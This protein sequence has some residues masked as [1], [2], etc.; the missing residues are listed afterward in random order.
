MTLLG[1]LP[2]K[3]EFGVCCSWPSNNKNGLFLSSPWPM[4]GIMEVLIWLVLLL[5]LQSS[6]L[7]VAEDDDDFSSQ[8]GVL[9]GY[10][11]YS[12]SSNCFAEPIGMGECGLDSNAT[13]EPTNATYFTARFGIP[14]NNKKNSNG[15]STT[16]AGG[17]PRVKYCLYGWQVIENEEGFTSFIYTTLNS[18]EL[19]ASDPNC[20]DNC[21]AVV[22][23]HGGNIYTEP[24]ISTIRH[25][26]YMLRILEGQEEDEAATRDWN[27][28]PKN[29]GENQPP[30]Y[31]TLQVT[32][33]GCTF[34]VW[35]P[36][37]TS[38][39]SL[40]PSPTSP[41]SLSPTSPLVSPPPPTSPP[42]S[43][44]DSMGGDVAPTNNPPP[45]DSSGRTATTASYW[46]WT[47]TAAA[48]L[49]SRC[50]EPY[51]LVFW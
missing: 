7:V 22:S 44:L 31:G 27:P 25:R 13:A 49:A 34:D 20:T 19:A 2:N 28:F 14:T 23:S 32:A 46:M 30:K 43:P 38:T 33:D 39:P 15:T 11:L 12:S 10:R 51:I 37:P 4:A 40:S 16:A 8:Q 18:S 35:D 50:L 5:L 9:A 45:L 21:S 26:F 42:V 48:L 3:T 41:P 17:E 24:S 29:P 6:M 47:T 36:V 1:P